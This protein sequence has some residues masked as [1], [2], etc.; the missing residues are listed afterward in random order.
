VSNN[1][2]KLLNTGLITGRTWIASLAPESNTIDSMRT[3]WPCPD[4]APS[5][6]MLSIVASRG[7]TTNVEM[8]QYFY[9][10]KENI[11]DP[12]LLNDME[13]A[14][15]RVLQAAEKSEKVAV[16]G[17]FDVDGLT[18]T[19]LIAQTLRALEV[20]GSSIELMEPF[21]PDRH[22]DGYGVA[23]RM[24]EQW[25]KDSVDLLITIDTGSSAQAEVNRAAELGMDVIILDHHLFDVQPEGVHALVNPRAIDDKYPNSELCGVAVGFKLVQALRK[26]N[27]ESLPPGFEN[28]VIDLAALGLVSDQMSLQGENRAIVQWGMEKIRSVSRVRPGVKALFDVSNL[29]LGIASTTDVAYQIAPRLNACGRIGDV[30]VALDLLKEDL[31]NASEL[32]KTA[33]REN[34]KRR[35]IDMSLREDAEQMAV[36]FVDRGDIGLVLGSEDWH[37]GIV[38]IGASR[39][40]ELYNV[41]SILFSFEKGEARGSARS[42]PGVDVKSVLDNC[43]EHLVRYG[44]H[45]MAAGLTLKCKDLDSFRAAFLEALANASGECVVNQY[46][47]LELMYQDMKAENISSLL[48]E[49]ELLEPYGEGNRRPV[50]RCN[51]LQMKRA[52]VLM[53]KT[54]EHLKFSFAGIGREFVSFGSGRTW[55]EEVKKLGGNSKTFDM[56]WD[57]LFQLVPNKWRPRN[58]AN[59]DPVQIQLTDI[60]PSKL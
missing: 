50:F 29:E 7:I 1:K 45:A 35:A 23:I 56:N 59:V 46:Y 25:G 43:S 19:A 33:N 39:M 54:G 14:A 57:V 34:V 13:K 9:P 4:A 20:N 10:K 5:P 17:D 8:E 30:Q 24:I 49:T 37:R 6:N 38:G 31:P 42:I 27:S 41:P 15:L 55:R 28:E 18:G 36:E 60:M 51:K 22:I 16:H 26:L 32:A 52:P 58:N 53:G 2:E 40:V 44:G 21:V 11:H 47:D 12:L 48:L 3:S